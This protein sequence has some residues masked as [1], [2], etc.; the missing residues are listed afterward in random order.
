MKKK[1]LWAGI[2]LGVETAS[3]CIIDDAGDVLHEAA[4]PSAVESVRH[5]LARFRRTRFASVAFESGV[6]THIARAMRNRG[7]PVQIYE[8]RQ[9]SKF[10]RV[11]RNKTDAGDA[12]GIAEAGRICGGAEK[13]PRTRRRP[14]I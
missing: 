11:R 5:H 2:D 9:L 3:V 7:Y 8:A 10:L 1:W 13:W 14:D 4:C 12:R 6:G